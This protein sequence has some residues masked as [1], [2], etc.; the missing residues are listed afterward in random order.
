[1]DEKDSSIAITFRSFVV[2]PDSEDDFPIGK[3]LPLRV[4]RGTPVGKLMEKI[5]A[6][7]APDRNGGVQR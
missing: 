7:K 3:H 2:P 5:F 1:M 4:S 6:G